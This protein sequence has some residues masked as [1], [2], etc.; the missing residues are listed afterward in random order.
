MSGQRQPEEIK[1]HAQAVARV[2]A[3]ESLAKEAMEKGDRDCG[4]SDSTHYA[5]AVEF[6]KAAKEVLRALPPNS[7][8]L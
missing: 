4:R 6:Y 7:P 3:L 2:K 1:K 8:T 5:R